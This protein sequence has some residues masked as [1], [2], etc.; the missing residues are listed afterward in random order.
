MWI[1]I[2]MIILALIL[3][4]STP[5]PKPTPIPEPAPIVKPLPANPI[6]YSTW[7]E[8]YAA[9]PDFGMPDYTVEVSAKVKNVGGGG[10]I[11]ITATIDCGWQSYTKTERIYFRK[12]QEKVIVFLF[13]EATF[14]L[15]P[16]T[17]SIDARA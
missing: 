16:W 13:P 9:Y 12:G 7:F 1:A 14:T 15:K 17:L 6:V 8:E 3:A 11:R 4:G 5:A 10:W 2:G